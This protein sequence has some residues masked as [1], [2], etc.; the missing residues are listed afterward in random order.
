LFSTTCDDWLNARINK[1]TFL[2]TSKGFSIHVKD[3]D[4]IETN[5]PFD[6]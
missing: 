2:M 5:A 1:D 6:F 3:Q 4:L